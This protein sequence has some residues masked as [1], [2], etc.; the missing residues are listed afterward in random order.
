M[1]VQVSALKIYTTRAQC[2]S[3]RKSTLEEV[4]ASLLQ[5]HPIINAAKLWLCKEKKRVD[6]YSVATGKLNAHYH[7]Y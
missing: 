3:R 4:D 1:E 5:H 2:N 6:F 7:N